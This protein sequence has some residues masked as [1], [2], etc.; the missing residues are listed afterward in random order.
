MKP[1]QYSSDLT[2]QQRTFNYRMSRAHIVIENAFGRLKARW[3]RL[4]KR[5]DMYVHNVPVV[6]A[7]VCILHNICE[8]HHEHCKDA[9]LASTDDLTQ[10]P[11]TICQDVGASDS[12]SRQVREA[13]VTYFTNN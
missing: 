9:W 11:P 5:N 12:R 6:A 7:T 2:S 13:L 1:F 3:L 10:P 4:M 8:I